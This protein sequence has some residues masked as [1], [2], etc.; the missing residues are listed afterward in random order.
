MDNYKYCRESGTDKHCIVRQLNLLNLL[1]L[2][3]L[4]L[5]PCPLILG[6]I[7]KV[8]GRVPCFKFPLSYSLKPMLAQISYIREDATDCNVLRPYRNCPWLG[9]DTPGESWL[10]N[11]WMLSVDFITL[12]KVTRNIF[13]HHYSIIRKNI[14]GILKSPFSEYFFLQMFP[15]CNVVVKLFL[16]VLW[17]FICG[18]LS[19]HAGKC[20]LFPTHRTG[21]QMS[22][23][24]KYHVIWI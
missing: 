4:W 8:L 1:F 19:I 13:L 23:K 24:L 11:T 17:I 21:K 3:H 10:W 20:C 16:Y 9:Y 14:T 7:S 2:W 22:A 6:I 15:T 5:I 12:C 18:C